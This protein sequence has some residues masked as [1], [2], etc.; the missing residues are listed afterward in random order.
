MEFHTLS[1]AEQQEF[2]RLVSE[3]EVPEEHTLDIAVVVTAVYTS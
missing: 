2:D 3:L 1:A